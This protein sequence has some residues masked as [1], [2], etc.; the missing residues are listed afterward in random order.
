LISQYGYASRRKAEELIKKERVKVNG[1]IVKELGTKISKDSFIEINGKIINKDILKVYLILNKPEGYICSRNDHFGRKTIYE[2]IDKK[3]NDSGVF[4]VG[5]LDLRSQGIL[6]ITNDGDFANKISHPSYRILKKYEVATNNIIPYNLIDEWKKGI[7]IEKIKYKIEDFE[8]IDSKRIILFLR[9]GKNREIRR[10]FKYIG[11]E[12]IVL[13]RTAI[14]NVELGD[15]PLGKYR[16][17]T[18]KEIDSLIRVSKN[19]M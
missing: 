15:L 12:V 19:N 3:Y 18:A 8:K 16:E 5:R 14:G 4:N 6:I 10:L 2:L 17:L 7:Y 11:I 9:E 1:I 13:R